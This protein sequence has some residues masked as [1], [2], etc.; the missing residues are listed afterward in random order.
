M[1]KTLND[2][3]SWR[4]LFGKKSRRLK[5]MEL[6]V[7]AMAL[8]FYGD[9]YKAPM[10]NFLNKYMGTNRNLQKQSEAVLSDVFKRAADLALKAFGPT[11]F[12]PKRSVNA[13]V[14]DSILVGLARRLGR[15]EVLDIDGLK[16]AYRK[17][18]MND[19]FRAATETGTSQE[20]NVETR[21]R[22]ATEAFAPV[23]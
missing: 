3:A 4:T 10:T 18:M 11:A 23:R 5:D 14:A 1:L 22:L 13:A 19:V 16:A 12:K 17:L 21:L 15:G 9:K 8:F 7:R 2:H 20:A 6:I